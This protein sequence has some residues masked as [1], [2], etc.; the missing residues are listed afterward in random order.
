MNVPASANAFLLLK[1]LRK[2]RGFNVFVVSDAAAETE[3]TSHGIAVD[4]ATATCKTIKGGHRC[5]Q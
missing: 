1:V 3:L 4:P 2:E 5:R